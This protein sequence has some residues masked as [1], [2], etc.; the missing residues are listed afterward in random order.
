[1]E[2]F[3]VS[4]QTQGCLTDSTYSLPFPASPHVTL[5]ITYSAF[6]VVYSLY[7]SALPKSL[8][9][10]IYNGFILLHPFQHCTD[11]TFQ[12]SRDQFSAMPQLPCPSTPWHTMSDHALF[13]PTL[14]CSVLPCSGYLCH[15]LPYPPLPKGTIQ[16]LLDF[17]KP[18]LLCWAST[19]PYI[20]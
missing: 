4:S 8:Y 10:Y 17:F 12:L 1:M 16:S 18:F 11:F 5:A 20:F 13:C 19:Y 6:S 14:S 2:T 9:T 7:K 3:L 15:A